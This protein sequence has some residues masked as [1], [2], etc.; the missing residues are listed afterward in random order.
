MNLDA[1]VPLQDL[2]R[3]NLLT[4]AHYASYGKWLPYEWLRYLCPII[5]RACTTPNSRI[6]LNVPP[7]HG[8]SE[9]ISRWTPAWYLDAF[10][11]KRVM[12][13]AYES[14]FASE[15]GAKVRD[16]FVHNERLMTKLHKKAR[17]SDN[18]RTM[19][20]GGMTTAGVGGAIMGRG[21][22]LGIIDDPH[23]NWHE[24]HS[25]TYLRKIYDWYAATFDS[26]MEPGASIIVLMQRWQERDLCGFLMDEWDEDWELVSLPALCEDPE[27][28][29]IGREIN[30]A[31][32]PERYSSDNLLKRKR[33]V[34]PRRWAGL[35]QQRPAQLEGNI[36]KRKN[37]RFWTTNSAK[38]E[39]RPDYELL[40]EKSKWCERINSWDMSF[41]SF[42]ERASWVVGDYW[43]RDED[44]RK[45]LIEQF[46][47]RVSFTDAVLAVLS[48]K[49]RTRVG[50]V[51]VEKKANGPAVIDSLESRIPG[52]EG[53]DVRNTSKPA[54]A[55][56][57]QPQHDDGL[58]FLPDPEESGNEWVVDVINE[59]CGF[60][61]LAE[62][63]R[64]D[65]MTQALIYLDSHSWDLLFG[66]A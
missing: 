17:S 51:L 60:P 4:F 30:G 57:V 37:I 59:Y 13:C 35:Y 62:D 65:T 26:R 10:P 8:K 38:A 31:L 5:Q 7:R 1:N 55:Y 47:D 49:N 15:W 14:T 61:S 24:A 33:R 32:C 21:F 28:D 29:P 64:V 27:T 43:V 25:A 66:R 58:I 20:G 19:Y 22:D 16:E 44:D 2:W 34:G 36:F 6:I 45:F 39:R 48:M 40:P 54:R 50:K 56:A 63:D 46:R 23:K 9:L 11:D 52:I 42:E 12:L 18:W 3:A 53:F 41:G